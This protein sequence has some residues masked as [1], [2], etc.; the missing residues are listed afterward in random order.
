MMLP[1]KC[2]SKNTPIS[3]IFWPEWPKGYCCV[4]KLS[5]FAESKFSCS[6]ILVS[7]SD[8]SFWTSRSL[9]ILSRLIWNAFGGTTEDDDAQLLWPQ[10]HELEGCPSTS[11]SVS[12]GSP[13]VWS[14]SSSSPGRCTL[15]RAIVRAFITRRVGIRLMSWGIST[16]FAWKSLMR[17]LGRISFAFEV[18]LVS[19][20][21][22]E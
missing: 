20:A 7:L 17:R 19:S 21:I 3:P 13:C 10:F 8:C 22:M 4:M 14:P 5:N 6:W 2:C 11:V 15:I 9:S 18:V 12:I 16:P 1:L